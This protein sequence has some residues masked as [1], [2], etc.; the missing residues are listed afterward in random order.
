MQITKKII[1]TVF[2]ICLALSMYSQ[3]GKNQAFWVHEDQVKPSMMA[4]YE[5]A[6]KELVAACKQNN[7]KNMQWSVASMND[8]TYL[9]ITP[10]ESL[11]DIQNM[12]FEDLKEKIGEDS[13][14]KMF[15]NFDKCYNKHGDYVTILN[16]SLSYMPNGLNTNTPGQDYRVWHRMEVTPDNMQKIQAKMKELKELFAAKNSKMQYRIYQSGFGNVGNSFV[17]VI[18]AKDAMDYD[19]MSSENDKILGEDGQKLFDEMFQYVEN[20]KVV[21]GSMRPDLAYQGAQQETKIVKE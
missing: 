7:L 21:R 19:R 1:G 3:E 4:E 2:C 13:F 8:G 12:N 6:S 10:I 11:A 18:S 9:A 17:A 5:K 16:P 14:N 15:E 20:Y